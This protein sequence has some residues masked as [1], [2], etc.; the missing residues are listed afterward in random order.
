MLVSYSY[1]S[2]TVTSP[3]FWKYIINEYL[4]IN[5]SIN[6]VCCINSLYV[7]LLFIDT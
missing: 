6:S 2:T 7:Y 3:S 1:T 5:I 4:T